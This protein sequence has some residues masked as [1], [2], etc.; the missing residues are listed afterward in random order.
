MIPDHERSVRE[1]NVYLSQLESAMDGEATLSRMVGMAGALKMALAF[2]PV[3]PAL[4]NE[5][6]G[7]ALSLIMEAVTEELTG[8][9]GREACV[10]KK[11]RDGLEMLGP[12]YNK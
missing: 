6:A 8:S 5:K 9:E 3:C 7:K 12:A 2:P 11:L 1:R 10:S 4:E